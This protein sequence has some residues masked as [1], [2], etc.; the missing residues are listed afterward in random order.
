M[1]RSAICTQADLKA[2]KDKAFT[3][4]FWEEKT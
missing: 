3:E 2:V 4:M 1:V